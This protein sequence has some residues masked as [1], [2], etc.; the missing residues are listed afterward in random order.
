M[1]SR[2][3]EGGGSTAKSSVYSLSPSASTQDVVGGGSVPK[4]F[5]GPSGSL[6]QRLVASCT[7]QEELSPHHVPL[8]SSDSS[9][10][11]EDPALGHIDAWE[12]GESWDA[13]GH[14]WHEIQA[15]GPLTDPITGRQV[16]EHDGREEIH[17]VGGP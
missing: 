12:G 13:S 15:I 9:S 14:K 3:Q 16:S 5:P 11:D 4:G 6:S 17:D 10:G 2:I 8:S 7:P 1:R